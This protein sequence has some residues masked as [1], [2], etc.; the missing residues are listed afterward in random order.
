MTRLAGRELVIRTTFR[1]MNKQKKQSREEDR[2]SIHTYTRMHTHIHIYFFGFFSL[3]L[4]EL[5]EVGGCSP[6]VNIH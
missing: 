5:I 4:S 2:N 6:A 1:E 3:V